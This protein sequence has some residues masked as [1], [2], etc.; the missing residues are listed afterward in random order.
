MD[1]FIHY[2]TVVLDRSPLYCAEMVDQLDVGQASLFVDFAQ[3]G[4]FK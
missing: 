3:G 2:I 1:G 4:L